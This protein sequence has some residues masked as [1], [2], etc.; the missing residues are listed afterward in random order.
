MVSYEI[1]PKAGTLLFSEDAPCDHDI[2]GLWDENSDRSSGTTRKPTLR[3]TCGGAGAGMGVSQHYYSRRWP[4]TREDE[5][6]VAVLT[7]V[8]WDTSATASTVGFDSV[9]AWVTETVRVAGRASGNGVRDPVA[10]RRVPSRGP[11]IA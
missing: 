11:A 1:G 4:T 8:S 3:T 2:A 7:N 6:V 5:S 10:S 9:V